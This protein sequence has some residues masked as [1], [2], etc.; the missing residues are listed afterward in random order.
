M[1]IKYSLGA[2][3][4]ASIAL[5]SCAKR[6]LTSA[7][8][9]QSG[10]AH[11]YLPTQK[12]ERSAI[13]AERV[14]YQTKVDTIR[15]NHN[16]ANNSS[17]DED[18]SMKT[19]ELD[20]FTVIADRPKVKIST[21]RNGRINLSFLTTMPSAFMD[22]RY[23]VVLYPT[24]ING[25][26]RIAMPPLVLQGSKFREVQDAEYAK[27]AKFEESIIDSTK[28]DSI[29]FDRKRHDSFITNLQRSYLDSYTRDYDL[30]IRYDR[31]KQNM[32]QRYIDYNARV[33]GAYDSRTA[34]GHLEALR[35][36]YD[37]DLYGDDSTQIRRYADSL[38]TTERRSNTIASKSRTIRLDEVPR[39]FRTLYKYNLTL[40]SIRNKSVTEQDSI[41]VARHTYKYRDIARNEAK[42]DNK[43][44]IKGHMVYLKRI[45]SAHRVETIA[46]GQDYAYL[47]SEDIAVTEDLQR[48]LQI[49]VDTRVTALDRSTWW[50]AGRDTLSYIVSGMNDLVDLSQAKRLSGSDLEEYEQGLKRLAVRDYYGALEIF[51]RYPDYNAAVCLLALGHNTQA[52]KF[53]EY[54]KPA[55]GKV[56]YLKAI[57]Q[58][59]LG[60][61]SK[62]KEMLLSAAR[63]DP[64]MGYRSEIDPEFANLFHE[65]P[66][67]LKQI[68][69]ISGGDDALEDI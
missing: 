24:L 68:L 42:R 17:H 39:A 30:Q 4:C 14:S 49:V 48:K 65:D 40:D 54:L 7:L 3:A 20:L 1:N 41:D 52:E 33:A 21:V 38:Y 2:I 57:T 25:D 69:D 59:R 12:E 56:D 51:N 34:T 28:Y 11:I 6:P 63:K 58:L 26:K 36:A 19:R 29:Y 35:K 62:A 18:P 43:A 60:N 31:W 67:L 61:K 66:A 53:L 55:N 23:Q 44:T 47:Y 32:E 15:P 64:Q 46:P 50:Q 37:L 45:D 8:F 5:A 10:R 13:I 27:Y 16:K 9:E 22:E